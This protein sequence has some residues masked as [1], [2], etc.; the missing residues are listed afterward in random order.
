MEQN[1]KQLAVDT[2]PIKKLAFVI[3]SHTD[4]GVNYCYNFV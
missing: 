1:F 3:I 4:F 2:F